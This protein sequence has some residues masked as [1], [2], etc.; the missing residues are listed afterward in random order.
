ML[1][2]FKKCIFSSSVIP[3]LFLGTLFL[4]FSSLFLLSFYLNN[5]YCFLFLFARGLHAHSRKFLTTDLL[6]CTYIFPVS[7]LKLLWNKLEIE[8]HQYEEIIK[9]K[10][11]E[12]PT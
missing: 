2:S 1:I 12:L 7:D 11:C 9:Q 10:R 4:W 5:F 3:V 8:I 6:C